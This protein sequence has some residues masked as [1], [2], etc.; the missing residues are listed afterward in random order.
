M[1]VNQYPL[2]LYCYYIII[3]DNNGYIG[4]NGYNNFD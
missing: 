1:S 2:F 4:Y 3:K